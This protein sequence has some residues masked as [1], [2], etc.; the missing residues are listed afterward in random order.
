MDVTVTD[1]EWG[2]IRKQLSKLPPKKS[3]HGRRRADDREIFEA[4]L[5]LLAT[6]SRWRDIPIERYPAKSSCYRRFQRWAQD[7][8]LRRLHRALVNKLRRLKKLNL[9]SG[10]ID[11]T[12]I[13]AKKG[14]SMSGPSAKAKDLGLW[15]SLKDMVYLS[16]LMFSPPTEMKPNSW[17]LPLSI[18]LRVYLN[19]KTS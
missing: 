13:K 12:E 17:S 15:S 3:W 18:R 7:G 5:W 6:G 4:L 14:V 19:Q 1:L 9:Q 8:S 10:F 2:F 11:G 16:E